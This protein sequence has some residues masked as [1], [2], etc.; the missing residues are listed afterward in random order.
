MNL[1]QQIEKWA[2]QSPD[3]TCYRWRGKSLTYRELKK[4]SDALAC[5]LAE[6]YVNDSAPIIIH[7]HMQP[8]MPILFLAC[9][10]SGHAYIPV[11][12]AIPA[13]RILLIAESSEAGLI[14]SEEPGLLPFLSQN[15]VDP[16]KLAGILKDYE[17][18]IPDGKSEVAGNDTFY[19]IYTSGSTGKPKGVQI[20]QD[21]LAS[22]VSWAQSDFGLTE[23]QIFL[24][25]APYSFDLSVMDLYPC[26]TTGGTLQTVD[27][28]MIARPAELFETFASSGLNVWTSTPSFAEM[29]LMEP[30]FSEQMMPEL[31]TFLF[32][33]ETL[34]VH[35]ARN[36]YERFPRAKIINTY[37]P[38]ESTV[39]VTSITISKEMAASG[40]PFPVG[41]C[42]SDC[43]IRILD[44]NGQQ[45]PEGEKG[46]IVI[47]G[48]SVGKGYLGDP[49]KTK[50]AFGI[51]Q[52]QRAY[53][54]SDIGSLQ[55]GLLYY[56]GRM[57]SQIK[58][59]GFRMELGEIEHALASCRYVRQAVVI[60]VK[61]EER[62]DHLI[63]FVVAKNNPFEKNYQLSSSI[64]NEL[65]RFLPDYMLPR[66]FIFQSSLPMTANGKVDRK[67]LLKEAVQ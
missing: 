14:F 33:G 2:E 18:Q 52:G 22:F 29:C 46:E 50:A 66:K 9:A 25:Q 45:V 35:V 57:D 56:H 55:N 12:L 62:Y 41:R 44:V 6:T 38:T 64:R 39:A 13:E 27:K 3:R 34:P 43:A 53:H 23:K 63:S 60:P 10:K 16:D 7:G 30:S 61:K 40:H 58:I 26:L 47:C 31:H 5:W 20:P 1:L 65:A 19:I 54:T 42:K 17:N 36:L 24:N 28:E 32:C 59:H 37:G 8:E 67:V 51:I 48:P 4:K 11:D 21:A 15:V 49:E